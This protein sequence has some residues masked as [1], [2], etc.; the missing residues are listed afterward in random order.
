MSGRP[1]TFRETDV[2]RAVNAVRAAGLEIGRV[3]IGKDGLIAVVP[4]KP[5]SRA[6]S[7]KRID[8]ASAAPLDELDRELQE[9]EARHGQD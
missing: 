7:A 2:K 6:E 4:S 8:N 3:E 9:F 1:S 5:L